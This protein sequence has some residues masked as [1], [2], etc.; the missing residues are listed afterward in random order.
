M[1]N[2]EQLRVAQK[3]RQ[4]LDMDGIFVSAIGQADD[5]CLVSNCVF[6][7]QN[8]LQ[9]TVEYCTKY[10]V[11]LVP[12]KTKL[13][14]F[15][16]KGMETSSFYWKL[17][18]PVSLGHS[19][20]NFT[21]EA[22]HVG[23]VRSVNGNLPNLMS[24]MSAHTNAMRAV[25]PAGLA[26]G[27]RGNPAAALRVEQRYGAPVL[28]SGLAALVHTKAELDILQHHYKLKLESLQHL[29]K[30]TPQPV[31]YFLGGSLPLPAL[32][33]IRQLS[34]LSMI[35]QLGP[36]HI[37]HQHACRVL[38][39]RCPSPH[40][41]FH[42]VGQL[43]SQYHLPA[44]LS[45]LTDPPTKS[46]LKRLIK[47][48]VVDFWETKLRAEAAKLELKFLTYFK[49]NFYS[50]TKH[51]PIWSMASSNPYEIEKARVQARM[52]SGRYRTCWLT[53]H[54]SGDSSG[55]CALPT[56]QLSGPTSGTLSHILIEC[57][58]LAEARGRAIALWA[59]YLA[60]K[61]VLFPI[62]RY[63]T[64]ESD[65]PSSFIQLLLDCSVMSD[66]VKATQTYGSWV[67]NSFFYLTRSY[68]YSIHKA[69]LKLLGKWNT[70]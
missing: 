15:T 27:H 16:P 36:E 58:D 63:H 7:L 12:E 31:V 19:K 64:I 3:S 21:E 57:P 26:R 65:D 2:N 40:S 45:I 66:V 46:S 34:L 68:C 53:R 44:P 13:L 38:T 33:H 56:C 5:S 67:L 8:L 69:R 22:E 32:L 54:W 49:S 11:E 30:A 48:R 43:C 52:V 37:L 62:V 10:H 47:S 6:K 17:V 50:L 60:D 35:A 51:Y 39:H 28:L 24:R 29:H 9:L 18:S 61:P 41:W 14:C 59:E 70:K 55:D 4:G 20:I 25:L 42:Q 1:A 23:I